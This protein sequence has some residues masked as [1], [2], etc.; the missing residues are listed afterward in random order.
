MLLVKVGTAEG[1]A[2]IEKG[3]V[4]AAVKVDGHVLLV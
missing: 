2:H 3:R 1:H 4:I